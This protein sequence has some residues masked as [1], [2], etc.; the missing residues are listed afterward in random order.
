MGAGFFVCW[1]KCGKSKAS[2]DSALWIAKIV[3]A[4]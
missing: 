3:S 4:M 1:G 2:T